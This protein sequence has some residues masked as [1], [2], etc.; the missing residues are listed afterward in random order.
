[1][2]AHIHAVTHDGDNAVMLAAGAHR[3][4]AVKF[5]VD[6][7]VD[8]C[9]KND[10]GETAIDHAESNLNEDPGKQEIIAFL[11]VKCGRQ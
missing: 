2:K 3:A 1:M 10:D 8:S 5:L 7:G 11:Q 6:L 4:D 9:A